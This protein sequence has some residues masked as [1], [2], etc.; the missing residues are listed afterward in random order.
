[1]L[2]VL[3]VMVECRVLNFL[4]KESIIEKLW[5]LCILVFL[6]VITTL[7]SPQETPEPMSIWG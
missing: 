6:M 5:L 4:K 3:L 1:M 2:L 7:T